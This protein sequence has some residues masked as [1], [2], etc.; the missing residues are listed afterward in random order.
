MTSKNLKKRRRICAVYPIV[1]GC[2]RAAVYEGTPK[3]CKRYISD[4]PELKNDCI[5]LD[6][7]N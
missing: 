4:H 1:D 3:Q 7:D 5:V 6:I 2:S